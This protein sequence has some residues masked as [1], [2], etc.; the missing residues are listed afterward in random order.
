MIALPPESWEAYQID[1]CAFQ[2]GRYIENKLEERDKQHKPI[3]RLE[4][5]LADPQPGQGNQAY[6]SLAGLVKRKVQIRPD[7]TWD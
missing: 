3:Y 7:G 1:L 6:R 5:L 2:L 4:D